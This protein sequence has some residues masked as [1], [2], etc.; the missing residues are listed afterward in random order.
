MVGLR[1]L[2]EL[3]AGQDLRFDLH[4]ESCSWTSLRSPPACRSLCCQSSGE[5]TSAQHGQDAIA[6][7]GPECLN[8]IN[9]LRKSGTS[10]SRVKM[11]HL[12]LSAN[13]FL[14]TSMLSL[15]TSGDIAHASQIVV[16]AAGAFVY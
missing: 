13:A 6:P 7:N 12:N 1:Q 16:I 2:H 15:V 11:R 8:G 5:Q 9:W 10:R 3:Q 4:L 14:T